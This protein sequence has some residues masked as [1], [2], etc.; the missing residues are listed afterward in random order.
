MPRRRRRDRHSDAADQASLS[1]R[2]A[3]LQSGR[4]HGAAA[5]RRQRLRRAGQEARQAR[6]RA[7]V[8]KARAVVALPLHARRAGH[9]HRSGIAPRYSRTMASMQL[10]SKVLV[11]ARHRV[12]GPNCCCLH[13]RRREL[14]Q[15]RVCMC[16]GADSRLRGRAA[17][18][19]VPSLVVHLCAGMGLQPESLRCEV[20]DA[21]FEEWASLD[22][23]QQLAD[24]VPAVLPHL[25]DSA[26]PCRRVPAAT[27]S[28]EMSAPPACLQARQDYDYCQFITRRWPRRLPLRS[29]ALHLQLL[30]CV[31]PLPAQTPC[32][33][34]LPPRHRCHHRSRLLQRR[35]RSCARTRPVQRKTRVPLFVTCTLNV[36]GQSRV[37]L[38][39]Q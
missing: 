20:W 39:L 3:G 30:C 14:C 16:R 32:A 2:A 24:G 28:E 12:C 9:V 7:Q 11:S 23:A 15:C 8:R 18:R 5:R 4:G 26:P 31:A 37:T 13:A 19:D 10:C 21:D 22:E 35:T 36:T 6:G 34:P 27:G 29:T 38:S 17:R 1:Q 33:V 25:A